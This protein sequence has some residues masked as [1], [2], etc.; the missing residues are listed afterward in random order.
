[1]ASAVFITGNS[2]KFREAKA[3]LRNIDLKQVDIDLPE[4][5]GTSQ[6]IVELK[7]V[8]G[9]EELLIKRRHENNPAPIEAVIVEDTSLGFNALNG[10]P[11]PYIKWFSKAIGNDGLYKMLEGFHNKQALAVCV[12]G[13]IIPGKNNNRPYIIEATVDG[14]IVK[15]RAVGQAFGWD[16][17]FQ[18]D[19][20]TQTFAEMSQHQKN[21]VSPRYLAFMEL[22]KLLNGK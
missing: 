20:Y 16:P 2:G 4:I 1:M 8:Q 7:T 22:S 21:Q 12:V 9:Y 14:Q 19:G 5:Q 15:P 3:I 6:E 11:G 18:P 13:C 10:L 17:I